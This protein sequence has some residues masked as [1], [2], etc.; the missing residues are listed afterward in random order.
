MPTQV[1]TIFPI[2]NVGQDRQNNQTIEERKMALKWNRTKQNETEQNGTE[3][4]EKKLLPLSSP[5]AL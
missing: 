3:V 4:K 2:Q 5:K 1:S